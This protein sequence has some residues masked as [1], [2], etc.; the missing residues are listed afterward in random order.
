MWSQFKFITFLLKFYWKST[1]N[2][3][4]DTTSAGHSRVWTLGIPRH[5]HTHMLFFAPLRSVFDFPLQSSTFYFV[6]SSLGRGSGKRDGLDYRHSRSSHM[7]TTF[8]SPTSSSFG[9]YALC[10]LCWSTCLDQSSVSANEMTSWQK[11]IH[12]SNFIQNETLHLNRVKE[13]IFLQKNRIWE[14]ARW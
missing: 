12:Q 3:N 11:G 2:Q 10:M 6:T 4:R 14:F 8:R 13:R 7:I 1:Q 9:D 5:P